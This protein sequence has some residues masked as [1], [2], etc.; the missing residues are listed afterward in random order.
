MS[1]EE[2]VVDGA[3]QDL[4]Y[5]VKNNG[6]RS[7]KITLLNGVSGFLLPGHLSALVRTQSCLTWM[8]VTMVCWLQHSRAD[9]WHSPAP[10]G[11]E[12]QQQDDLAR[13][14]ARTA[15]SPALATS[16]LGPMSLMGYV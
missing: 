2:A 3:V 6:N 8:S 14:A 1:A 4:K 13:Y 12:R 15:I 16:C 9:S 7:E 5:I 11:T 10:D